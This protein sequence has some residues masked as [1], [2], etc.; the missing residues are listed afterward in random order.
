M[1]NEVFVTYAWGTDRHNNKVLSLCDLLRQKG[2]HASIDKK[3]SQEENSINFVEMMHKAIVQYSKVI[4]VLSERYK[5][6]AEG[7]KGGVGEEYRLILSDI[8]KNRN[9][10]ILVSFEGISDN[11]V[12]LGFRDREI[13]D[14]SVKAK[15]NTLFAKLQDL[16]SINFSD[17]SPNKPI[18]EPDT[19]DDFYPNDNSQIK[20]AN[21]T[22]RLKLESKFQELNKA[23][24]NVLIRDELRLLYSKFKDLNESLQNKLISESQYSK[25]I[26]R[27]DSDITALI[28]N[29]ERTE[30]TKEDSN[31][32]IYEFLPKDHFINFAKIATNCFFFPISTWADTEDNLL[33]IYDNIEASNQIE[34]NYFANFQPPITRSILIKEL[35]ALRTKSADIELLEKIDDVK[36]IL[37]KGQ[38]KYL[39]LH[40]MPRLV[41][42][43][44]G[45][46]LILNTVPN[47]YGISLI[48]E[49]GIEIASLNS[50]EELFDLNSLAVRILY[51]FKN[52]RGKQ[53]AVFH[54]RRART[55]A[56][57]KNA[58]DVS[59]A[60]YI[61]SDHLDP[62]IENT[63]RISVWQASICELSEELG[64][65]KENL[66]YREKFAFFGVIKN[67]FT[68]QVD[69]LCETLG[70]DE[71]EPRTFAEGPVDI[72]DVC[73]LEPITIAKFIKSKKWWVPTA[74]IT[75]IMSLQSAGYKRKLIEKV[76][77][78]NNVSKH[79]KLTP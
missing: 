56:T 10:Y 65:P 44:L 17:V 73:E 43:K 62:E 53:V 69:L 41:K 6:K 9:K 3:M 74:I 4:I 60:G 51:K 8:N 20:E 32:G 39:R 37:M 67:G 7:F 64:I 26:V 15:M 34:L 61:D 66:P 59:A 55:N 46:N 40:N 35:D 47:F 49:K 54:K 27:L 13:L 33:K 22:Y 79:L 42:T 78:D 45:H 36:E 16:A 29:H 23:A 38:N 77:N 2:F 18:I 30:L 28:S 25:R 58:W 70:F 68:G 14:L 50:I 63:E 12:P 1:K 21:S 31:R 11:I 57:Y 76:F 48:E 5:N 52:K 19:I 72:I 75:I 24:S 71:V